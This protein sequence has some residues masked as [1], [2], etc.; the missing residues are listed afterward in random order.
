MAALVEYRTA[1]T[2][3]SIGSPDQHSSTYDFAF[4]NFLQQEYKFGADPNRP[5]CKAFEEGHCPLGNRCP[6]KH[7]RPSSLVCKHWLKALC[8]KGDQCEYLHEY[9]L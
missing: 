4:T 2:L 6:D 1:E 3:Q 8:K 5:V 9:N 7:H